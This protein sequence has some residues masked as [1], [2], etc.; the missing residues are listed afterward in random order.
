MQL[1]LPAPVIHRLSRRYLEYLEQLVASGCD[2]ARARSVIQQWSGGKGIQAVDLRLLRRHFMLSTLLPVLRERMPSVSAARVAMP[3]T[4]F[5]HEPKRSTRM[6]ATQTEYL[7]RR[8]GHHG[9]RTHERGVLEP[10]PTAVSDRW[11]TGTRAGPH[12]LAPCTFVLPRR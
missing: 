3:L 2:E 11:G 5:P 8:A 10:R 4:P 12:G 1:R 7:T 6:G 9:P